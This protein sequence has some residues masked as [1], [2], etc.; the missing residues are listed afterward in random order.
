MLFARRWLAAESEPGAGTGRPTLRDWIERY[1]LADREYRVR[2]TAGSPLIG[3]TVE[4]IDLTG[5]VGANLVTIERKGRF[6]SDVIA[7]TQRTELQADDVLLLDLFAPKIEI[8]ALRRRFR[9]EAL[10]LTGAYFSD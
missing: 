6:T 4:E 3:K 1:H 10:P 9:L 2:V 8:E 5:G 7:P